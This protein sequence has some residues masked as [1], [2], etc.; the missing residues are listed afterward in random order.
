MLPNTAEA[1]KDVDMNP[2]TASPP[3]L[4]QIGFPYAADSYATDSYHATQ[5][6]YESYSVHLALDP[7]L[8]TQSQGG[9]LAT[10]SSHIPHT[11]NPSLASRN[12]EYHEHH[13]ME[14]A[15]DAQ[16]TPAPSMGPPTRP[17]KR[18]A[19]TLHADAWEPYKAR[20]VELH[21]EQK[22]PLKKVK[23]TIEQ[24]SG[25]IA[26]YVTLLEVEQTRLS[27]C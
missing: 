1:Q 4:A 27:V 20:I 15:T 19:P 16:V 13:G 7:T 18:K 2:Q 14:P 5:Q 24:E 12:N 23:E 8:Q 3:T 26:E 10:G 22:L 9:Q 6:G 17:R 11:F 25:F 21:V